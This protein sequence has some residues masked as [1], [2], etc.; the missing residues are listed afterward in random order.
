LGYGNVFAKQ[1]GS[2]KRREIH[3][4]MELEQFLLDVGIDIT[5]SHG[6]SKNL[7]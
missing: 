3:D 5:K 4:E 7:I 2:L 1:E 6:Y